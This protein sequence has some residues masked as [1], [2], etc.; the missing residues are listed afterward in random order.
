MDSARYLEKA[1]EMYQ[2]KDGADVEIDDDAKVS[3][4]IDD[5]EEGAWVQSWVW[6]PVDEE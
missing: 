2:D 4:P 1:R 5:D 6:V 3:R